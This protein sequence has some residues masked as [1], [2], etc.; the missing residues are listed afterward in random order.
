MSFVFMKHNRETGEPTSTYSSRLFRTLTPRPQPHKA[1]RA[2]LEMFG[3]TNL[4]G[5]ANKISWP[6]LFQTILPF[7][8]P[9]LVACF[10][11]ICDCNL[12]RCNSK[13]LCLFF[14]FLC[15]FHFRFSFFGGFIFFAKEAVNLGRKQSLHLHKTARYN[16]HLSPYPQTHKGK[17]RQSVIRKASSK[18]ESLNEIL[19]IC[20]IIT[21]NPKVTHLND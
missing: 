3:Q 2:C 1:Q 17:K 5:W 19:Y 4:K 6:G 20:K 11:F 12:Y 14:N 15:Y 8:I 9:E 10:F 18:N 16:P 13:S 7:S 21:G